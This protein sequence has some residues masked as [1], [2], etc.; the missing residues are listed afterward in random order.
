MEETVEDAD[1]RGKTADYWIVKLGF[2]K[3]DI[4]SNSTKLEQTHIKN[5]EK[6]KVYAVQ[7]D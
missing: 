7:Q 4:G 3:S 6:H 1:A 2:E 5:D